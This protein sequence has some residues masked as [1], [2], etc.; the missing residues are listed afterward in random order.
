MDKQ[1]LRVNSKNIRA[2]IQNYPSECLNSLYIMMPEYMKK[3]AS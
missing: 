3:V 1:L 2:K